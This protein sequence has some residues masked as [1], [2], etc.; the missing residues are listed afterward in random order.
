MSYA[1]ELVDVPAPKPVVTV[2]VVVVQEQ[3]LSFLQEANEI[4]MKA[5]ASNVIFFIIYSF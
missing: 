1:P 3:V 2:V 4:A 5:I